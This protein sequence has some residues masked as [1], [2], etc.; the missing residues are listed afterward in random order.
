MLLIH[1]AARQRALH[2]SFPARLEV[3]PAGLL[4]P[5]SLEPLQNDHIMPRSDLQTATA[6]G[7]CLIVLMMVQIAELRI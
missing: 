3:R 7:Q 1:G 6:P 5:A 4:S 2:C